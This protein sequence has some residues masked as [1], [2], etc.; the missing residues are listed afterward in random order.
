MGLHHGRHV[1]P[2]QH[3]LPQWPPRPLAPHGGDAQRGS[4]AL[5]AAARRFAALPRDDG[6]VRQRM[7][8]IGRADGTACTHPRRIAM[9]VGMTGRREGGM[10]GRLRHEPSRW[11]PDGAGWARLGGWLL[12]GC[13][14][15]AMGGGRSGSQQR[16]AARR[17]CVAL[18]LLGRRYSDYEEGEVEV[19]DSFSSLSGGGRARCTDTA[20]HRIGRNNLLTE[21]AFVV[22]TCHLSFAGVTT[23]EKVA[24]IFAKR[25][26]L[27]VIHGLPHTCGGHIDHVSFFPSEEEVLLQP[28]GCDTPYDRHPRRHSFQHSRGSAT[29][30]DHRRRR[31]QR[32]GEQAQPSRC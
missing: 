20:R 11:F 24:R 5:P 31:R 3:G 23:N 22:G 6:S 15:Q 32:R 14:R 21:A 25:Q 13:T 26:A 7:G 30:C 19:W 17:C 18:A 1:P 29:H 12:V 28:G 27:M 2:F 8:R 9:R 10:E 16:P 4:R